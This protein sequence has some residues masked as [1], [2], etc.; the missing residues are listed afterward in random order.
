VSPVYW[1][2]AQRL[3]AGFPPVEQALREPDGLLAVGGDL[4]PG[5]LLEA[6]RQGIFPWYSAG[7]PILWWSP[8]PRTVLQ[9]AELK[10]SRSLRRTLAREIFHITCD[11]AFTR[12]LAAC[13]APRPGQDGTW[14][15]PEMQTAYR[16]LHAAGHAHSLEAWVGDELVGGLYGLAIGRVFFGESMFSRCSD[17]SKVAFVHLV[18]ALDA[19]GFALIDCQ[20][21]TDHLAS[22]GARP[23]PRDEFTACLSV[24][25]SLPPRTDP[26][27]TLVTERV[28]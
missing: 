11:R 20:V 23:I 9:P 16:R 28:G 17:A 8:N 19:A 2:S 4:Q 25:C 1:L 22:L 3:A 26:W 12:V 13:A 6:Y 14:L 15:T 21:H 5:R 24:H 10:V 18:R 7:Q 27:R